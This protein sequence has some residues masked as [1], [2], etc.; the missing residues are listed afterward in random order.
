M[1]RR[2]AQRL[3]AATTAAV[4]AIS[5]SGCTLIQTL[6]NG[7]G[8]V[9]PAEI[10]DADLAPELQEYYEQE[11]EWGPCPE[12]SGA[13]KNAECATAL[14]PMDWDN[15]DKGEPVELALVRQPATGDNPQG[16]L[17]SNPGGPG[18]SGFDFV[19]QSYGFFSSD[20][21]ENFDLVGW[22]PR[23][24]GRSSAVQCRDDAGMDLSLIHI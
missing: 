10:I 24:V 4:A 2:S 19:A 7:G 13:D 18:A 20:L 5:L 17:F 3:L 16:S 11:L 23:G 1:N 6:Q 8:Q 21:R 9:D 15:P 22:D 14:A 12:D